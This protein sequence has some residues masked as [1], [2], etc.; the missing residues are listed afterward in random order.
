MR[1]QQRIQRIQELRRRIQAAGSRHQ[2]R[3][4]LQSE[5]TVLVAEQIRFE[6]RQDRKR[7]A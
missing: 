6:N 1:A 3:K 2:V 4:D 5:L 7:A